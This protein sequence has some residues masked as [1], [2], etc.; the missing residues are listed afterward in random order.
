MK[1]VLVGRLTQIFFLGVIFSFCAGIILAQNKSVEA[2][3][4]KARIDKSLENLQT[5]SYRMDS[6]SKVVTGDT[7]QIVE[8]LVYEFVNLNLKRRVRNYPPSKT[9]KIIKIESVVI[10]KN[11]FRRDNDE[12]WEKLPAKYWTDENEI[13]NYEITNQ[14]YDYDGESVINDREVYV[15]KITGIKK[16]FGIIKGV[17]NS[18]SKKNQFIKNEFESETRFWIEKSNGLLLK[19]ESKDFKGNFVFVETK[20]YDYES[21]IKIEVPDTKKKNK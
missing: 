13:K 2:T 16:P 21:Q 20:K 19:S 5:K 11:L 10:D 6:V 17:I 15:Y 18:S 7:E 9:S 3:D 14:I 8:S 4:A 1:E 12:K